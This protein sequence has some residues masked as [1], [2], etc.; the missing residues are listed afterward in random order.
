MTFYDISLKMLRVNFRRYRLYFLCNVFSIVLF[1]C[2][3][4]IFTNKAFMN[5][6]IVDSSIS[7]NIYLP[8]FL[9][10]IFLILFVPYSY[11]AF[12]KNRKHE[13][14]ILMTLGMSEKEVLQNMLL[15]NCAIAGLSLLTGLILGTIIS[16]AFYFF[17]QHMIG[18]AG[19][20]YVM[21][22]ASYLWTIALYGATILLTLVTGIYSLIKTK[23]TDVIKEKFRA[24]RKGKQ[25][26]GIF[27]AGVIL[28]IISIFVM[29]IG[30]KY[31]TSNILLVSL[32]AMFAGLCMI[33]THVERVEQYFTKI[34][35]GYRER[36]IPELSF[37]RQHSKSRSR[38]SIIA[39]W[40]IGFSVF[41]TGLCAVM[42]TGLISNSAS[43][44]PYDLVYSRIFGMN[45]ASDNEI[46]NLLEQND[47]TVKSLKQVDYL[48]SNAFNLLPV[49]EVNAVFHC[50]Y[51]IPEGRFLTIFQTVLNDGYA[52][53]MMS[54]DSVEFQCGDETKK[55]LSAGSDIRILFNKNPTFADMTLVIS[56]AD[57]HKIASECDD[58]WTGIMKLYTFD[59]W[60]ISKQGIDAVQ[61]YLFE[62]NQIKQEEVKYYKATSRIDNYITAR[63]S[64]EFIM[65]LMSF[66]VVLFCGASNVMIHFKIKAEAEEEERLLSGLHRIG[67]TSEEMQG[68]IRHKNLYYFIPQVI[69]G[70][71]IGVFY[72]YTVNEF[73][74]YG[75]EAVG[76]S[77]CFGM[78]LVA[79]QFVVVKRYSKRE[80]LSFRI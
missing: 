7:S 69:I 5:Y 26:P 33:I 52:H 10:G 53:D 19:L 35:P 62:K 54:M 32:A 77:L 60:K 57:Y 75:W 13:Y 51:Q 72:N 43:Y 49:S 8:S 24:E 18:I 40:M 63:Q 3:A 15:E 34:A 80:L 37:I 36:H 44:S 20:H 17:I 48:R 27:R 38:I 30:Y 1:Y 58:L 22:A 45:Q 11:Q 28:A 70:L 47:V 6:S 12:L 42:Y 56:D 55:L 78:V 71:F 50:N 79:L 2:F 25:L 41:F 68:M 39:A 31:D 61:Q 76:Y 73:L 21:N 9:V 29:V 23:L 59:N 74:G 46:I 16:F 67:I 64:A 66:I 65:F 14:G 4:A